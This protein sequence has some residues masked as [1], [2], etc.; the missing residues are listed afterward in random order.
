MKVGTRHQNQ[1]LKN[2]NKTM[3]KTKNNTQMAITGEWHS[4]HFKKKIISII[5]GQ[6]KQKFVCDIYEKIN[7]SEI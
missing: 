5:Q 3:G 7:V 2:I 4:C 1:F 6:A